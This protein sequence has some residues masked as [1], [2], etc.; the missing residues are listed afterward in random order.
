[1]ISLSATYFF[2]KQS[3]LQVA[4]KAS[5]WLSSNKQTKQTA[6]SRTQTD[7]RTDTDK[8]QIKNVARQC[9]FTPANI[10]QKQTYKSWNCQELPIEEDD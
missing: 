7:R 6:N 2:P 4:T 9:V 1:M 10:L 8:Q 5:Q 3:P